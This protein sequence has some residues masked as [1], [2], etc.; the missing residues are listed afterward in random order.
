MQLAKKLYNCHVVGVCSGR[1]AE[2]VRSMGADEVLDYTRE[3]VPRRLVEG[4]P[5]GR[6]YD[7]YVDCVGGV[8][9]FKHWVGGADESGC[10]T[11]ADG[12]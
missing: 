4:M 2:F 12:C 5:G 11:G 3:D 10:V 7:L 6:K 8:G 1:N 9:M